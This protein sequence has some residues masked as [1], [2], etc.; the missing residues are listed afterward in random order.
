MRIITRSSKKNMLSNYSRKK[1][2]EFAR[3]SMRLIFEIANDISIQKIDEIVKKVKE[4]F[5]EYI[6]LHELQG[7]K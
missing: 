6:I 5:P 4:D 2:G 1:F 7:Y 3:F